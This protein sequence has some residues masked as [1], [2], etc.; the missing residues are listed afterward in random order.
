MLCKASHLPNFRRR[1]KSPDACQVTSESPLLSSSYIL[2]RLQP[3]VFP[4]FPSTPVLA[5]SRPLTLSGWPLLSS[6]LFHGSRHPQ[7][8]LHSWAHGTRLTPSLAFLLTPQGTDVCLSIH[9]FP[10]TR[11]PLMLKKISLS[12]PF[13]PKA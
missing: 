1:L 7:W 2:V 8:L 3:P 10:R 12:L 11:V 9:P 5:L 4:G 13:V 6:L